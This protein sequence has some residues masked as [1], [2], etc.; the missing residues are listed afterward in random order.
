LKLNIVNLSKIS[1]L[2][3][4]Q[5]SGNIIKAGNYSDVGHGEISYKSNNFNTETTLYYQLLSNAHPTN[6]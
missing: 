1:D 4:L 6:A 2:Q 3:I 5:L